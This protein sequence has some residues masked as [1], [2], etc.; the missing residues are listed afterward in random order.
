MF[1]ISV[2]S[3]SQRRERASNSE[4]QSQKRFN[5]WIKGLNT[6]GKDDCFPQ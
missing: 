2:T 3:H 4:N 6:G 1:E 5:I